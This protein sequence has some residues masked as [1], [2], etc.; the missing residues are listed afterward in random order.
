ME[1]KYPFQHLWKSY[2]LS[3]DTVSSPTLVS[4]PDSTIISLCNFHHSL[5]LLGLQSLYLQIANETCLPELFWRKMA[6]KEDVNTDPLLQNFSQ[7][8]KAN[9]VGKRV[10]FLW[11]KYMQTRELRKWTSVRKGSVTRRQSYHMKHLSGC[12]IVP[13]GSWFLMQLSNAEG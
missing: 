1:G 6:W 12:S 5:K 11:C 9:T 8:S 7:M 2:N 3:S 13:L 4:Y 10:H